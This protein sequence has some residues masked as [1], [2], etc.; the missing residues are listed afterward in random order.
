MWLGGMVEVP[1]HYRTDLQSL[2]GFRWRLFINRKQVSGFFVARRC[3]RVC[4]QICCRRRYRSVGF[5]P[6]TTASGTTS[7][8]IVARRWPSRR[9]TLRSRYSESSSVR[10]STGA[11][12]TTNSSPSTSTAGARCIAVSDFTGKP[13]SPHSMSHRPSSLHFSSP[14]IF[15]WLLH[16]Y[17]FQLRSHFSLGAVN[18]FLNLLSLFSQ[19]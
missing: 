17:S 3:L 19:S 11:S 5:R 2:H 6:S 13:E 1:V 12:T 16:I 7:R 4:V 8:A 9:S 14:R 18:S 10:A 15:S